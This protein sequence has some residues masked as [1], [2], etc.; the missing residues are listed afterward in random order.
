MGGYKNFGFSVYITTQDIKT[1]F[2]GKEEPD[3]KL[4]FFLKYTALTKVYLEY[5]RGEVTPTPLL[6]KAKEYFESKGIKTAAGIMPVSTHF[7]T[8]GRM[9]CFT[10]PEVEKLFS[11][12]LA[13][14]AEYF[15]E[16]MID[17]S[18]STDCTCHRCIKAKGTRTWQEFRMDLMTEFSKKYVMEPI[19][20]INK[21]AKVTLKYPTWHESYQW[22]GYNTE[23]Q[24][25]IYDEIYAGTETR[26]TTY[27]LFRNPRYTSYSLIRYLQSLPPHN[28]RGGWF[29]SIQ[30]ANSIDI[31]TQQAELT[32]MAAP[33][34]ITLFCWGINEGKLYVPALGFTMDVLDKHLS[35]IGQP[36]GIPVY[37][38]FHSRGEDHVF[39]FMGMCGIPVDPVAI[40][41]QK[42]C[43]VILTRA[44][45]CDPKIVEK[46]KAHLQKGGDVCMTSGCLE[47][48]QDLGIS[49]C[50][51]MRATNRS[52]LSNEFGGFDTGW[53][54]DNEY[55]RAGREISMPVIDWITNECEFICM[56]MRE[57]MPNILLA[58]SF[59]A[60]G[61]AYVLNIPDS[62]SDMYEIPSQVFGYVRKYLSKFMPLW[63]EG[64]N[65]IALFPRSEKAAAVK[66]FLEHGAVIL[67]HIKGEPDALSNL[68][69]GSKYSPLYKKSGESVFRVP[70]DPLTMNLFTWE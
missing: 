12:G 48:L 56:Q 67:L 33:R 57:S 37:L 34:E 54:P 1:L 36:D 69:T 26:H 32:L 64:H 68:Q 41:P 5:F 21:N 31:F 39:D 17:D 13:G 18:F 20:A 2:S 50:T 14:A 6:L 45:A 22:M 49:D 61:K 28:N 15:D 4:G 44:S 42:P 58:R 55:H 16:I 8:T 3:N 70:L 9:L 62:Y 7:E 59:Y 27:S 60:E 19:R 66:S 52:Q 29:D 43:T 23:A 65:K 53:S 51:A 24:P 30:C 63:F 10:N 46:I 35:A 11:A 47:L 38:P 25:H 40:F